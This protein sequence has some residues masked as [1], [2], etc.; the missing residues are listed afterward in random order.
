MKKLF[1]SYNIPSIRRALGLLGD[2]KRLFL[3]LIW[4]FC[5]VEVAGGVLYAVGVRGAII[6]L[7]RGTWPALAQNVALIALNHIMWWSYAPISTYCCARASKNAVCRLKAELCERIIRMPMPELDRRDSGELLSVLTNDVDA[8]SQIYDRYYF[9][10][11]RTS[12]GGIAALTEMAAIDWRFALVVLAL[13]T[14]STLLSASFNKKLE[15]GGAALQKALAGTSV[16][17]YALIKGAKTL[18]LSRLRDK[19]LANTAEVTAREAEAKR[20]SGRLSARLNAAVSA[21]G[22]IT[23]AAIIAVGAVFV[24]LGLSDWGGVVALAS[25]KIATDMLFVEFGQFMA[26]TQVSVAAAKRI[27]ALLDAPTERIVPENIALARSEI[28]LKFENVNFAYGNA[29]VLENFSFELQP[30]R[31]TALTGAS[32]SGKSTI[33][34]LALGLYAPS[35]GTV[36][37][38]GAGDCTL[39]AVRGL[40]AYV[41]QEPMLFR[42]TVLDNILCGNASATREDAIRAAKLAGADIFISRMERGYGSPLADGGGNLS[43]GQKQRLAIARALVKD[44]PVLLLDEITSALDEGTERQILETVRRLAA[45]RTVLFVTH[46]PAVTALADEVR[47]LCVQGLTNDIIGI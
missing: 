1:V 11:L 47:Q 45:A 31:L 36:T 4:G 12:I 35:G 33:V 9:E 38:D 25:L 18:R 13:G 23:Y 26:A 7:E 5:A 37:F 30:R 42:G 20:G 17:A 46:R 22:A 28:P 8:M 32:G 29:P 27:F 43:G 15:R 44:A 19:L 3:A 14:A 16:D 40:T 24:R 21:V 41:P 10:L 2:R 34:K 39:E 6:A